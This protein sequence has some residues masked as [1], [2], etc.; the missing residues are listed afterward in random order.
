MKLTFDDN[1]R[2]MVTDDLLN[3]VPGFTGKSVH[4]APYT[5]AVE[6]ER[7][8]ADTF[9]SQELLWDTPDVLRFNPAG[10]QLVG[11]EFQLPEESASAEESA[12]LPDQPTSR[13][14]GLRAD[15]TRDFRHRSTTVLCRAPGDTALTCLR[16]L[17]VLADPIEARIE[18]APDLDLVVQH[19]N[20]VGWS[21]TNP[22]QYLTTGFT[23]PDPDP[24]AP[25]TRRLLT[26]CLD[27]I[28]QPVIFEVEDREPAAVARLR[29][30]D[31]ALRNQRYDRH[32]ADALLA[33]VANMVEDYTS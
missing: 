8:L 33:L 11:L 26:E 10:Q 25:A 6:R 5:N 19:S 18:I 17:D 28:T 23:E 32:R 31:D 7:F 24:P 27:L 16:D 1:W 30:V 4:V 9:G 15:E 12:R 21:L 13:P 14:G 3:I 29:A 2:A 20:V 22:V